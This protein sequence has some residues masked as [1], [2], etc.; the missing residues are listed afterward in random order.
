MS[1]LPS[2]KRAGVAIFEQGIY[3]LQNFLITTIGAT[4]LSERSFAE[5]VPQLTC[6]TFGFS[7]TSTFLS[8]P[9][10]VLLVKQFRDS[11]ASYL[12]TLF[13]VSL[14]F[15][16]PVLVLL[17][18]AFWLLAIPLTVFGLGSSLMM[19]VGTSMY[20]LHRRYSFSTD[21]TSRLLVHG[22]TALTVSLAVCGILIHRDMLSK[23]L[24]QLAFSVPLVLVVAMAIMP[25]ATQVTSGGFPMRDVLESHWRFSKYLLVAMILYSV[26]TQGVMFIS[27]CMLIDADV[28]GLRTTQ[29][30]ASILNLSF[31]VYDNQLTP[32]ITSMAIEK[33][34]T[35]VM[36][37]VKSATVKVSL[38]LIPVCIALVPALY[39]AHQIIFGRNFGDYS[40]LVWIFVL[41]LYFLGLTRPAFVG[42]KAIENNMPVMLG[43]FISAVAA[44]IFVFP[45][46]YSLGVYGA[47]LAMVI[48]P[49]VLFIVLLLSVWKE[50]E[51]LQLSSSKLEGVVGP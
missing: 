43:Y 5:L 37:W 23:E 40:S 10:Q 12:I 15:G 36:Q 20:D 1:K 41:Y 30:L 28:G 25:H 48:S 46:L 39:V 47:A 13:L 38:G 14:V 51:K 18:L 24:L 9:A 45:L 22:A 11:Q 29:T 34:H 35:S 42:F 16:L 8:T 17:A 7:L 3:A 32:R 27:S 33:S 21:G 31:V 6:V 19:F 44:L 2:I 26:S 49:A 4:F 50:N